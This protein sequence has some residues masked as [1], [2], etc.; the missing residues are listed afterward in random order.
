MSINSVVPQK[1]YSHQ[2]ARQ[3]LDAVKDNMINEVKFLLEQHSNLIYE[4][5]ERYQTALHWAAK[6]GHVKLI[7]LLVKHKANINCKDVAGRTPLWL[8]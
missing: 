4:F 2:C 7:C 1:P 5:D 3:F 6:R 8:A